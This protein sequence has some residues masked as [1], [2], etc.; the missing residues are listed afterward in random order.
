[1]QK[2]L[3]LAIVLFF[4]TLS[5]WTQVVTT[6]SSV[7]VCP[8]SATVEIPVTV[9]SFTAVGSISL[10]FAYVNSEITSPSVIYMDPGLTAWGTFVA[11][12]TIPGTII[13]SAFDPDVLP[14]TTGLTLVN[15]TTLFTLRFTIGTITTPAALTFVENSQG[16]SCEYGGVGPAYTPF[17]D[18]PTATYYIPGGV[19]VYPGFTAGAIAITNE[20]ICYNGDPV[21]I[22]SITPAS[23]GNGSIVY[24]WQSST[25]VDFASPTDIPGSNS[26]TYNPPANLTVSTWYRRQAKDGLC[27]TS[28]VTSSGVWKVTVYNNFTAGAISITGEFICNNGDP[29]LIG[30]VTLASGGNDVITYQWQSSTN[31]LFTSPVTINSN[32]ATYNPPANLTVSTW[33]RRQAKDGLCNT[34]W[35][36]SAGT[37][38]VTVY[39]TFIAGSI[40]TTD[41]T[42]CY[43]GDP[44]EI[45]S[46]TPASG[47]NEIITYQWQSSLNNGFS[48]PTDIPGSN[49]PTYNPPANLTT[50]TYYRRQAKDGLCYTSWSTSAGVW[51]VTVYPIFTA[52]AIATA[53]ETICYNG[54]P[55]VINS[56]TGATGGTGTI[57][58]QWQSSLNVDFTTPTDIPGATA[59]TYDPPANLAVS[60]WYRRQARDG[61]C[62]PAWVISAG[63]WSVT[64]YNNFTAGA[65]AT[66]G[67]TICYNGDPVEIGSITLAGGGN[68]TITYQWQSSTDQAF[69]TPSNIS[70]NT[71]TY[72]PPA[73]LTVTT[74]YRR[75]AK[76]GL[77][78]IS[79]NTSTGVW[80]VTVYNNFTAGSIATT[81]ETICYGGDPVE[82]GS[83]TPA[84]GGNGSFAYQ[85]QSSS[86]VGF[87]SPI[88]ITGSN[89]STYN[90]PANLTATTWYRR[91]AKDGLCNTSWNTSTG[92]WQVTV[93]QLQTISG[94]F[95]YHNLTA[96]IPL[97]AQDIT[98]QL[99][100][101]SD[102]SHST[103]LGT[104]VTD[105]SGNYVFAG[106]C[107]AC[108][109]DI[110][111]TTTHT[112]AGSVNTT[113]AAQVNYYGVNPY[114]IEK[115]RFHAGDVGLSG[116]PSDL[117]IN[118]TDA[119]RIQNNFVYGTA[120]DNNWTF[121]KKG[122]MITSASTTESYTSVTL[123]V[124]SNLDA[125][126][127]GLCTGDFNLS[128][129][130]TILKAASSTLDL[131]YTGNRQAGNNQE[132]DLPVR[133]V[134]SSDIGAVSLILKFPEDMVEVQDVLINGTGGQLDWAVKG[135]ELRIGWNSPSPLNLESFAEL[136]TLRMKT[137]TAF[138]VGNSIKISLAANPLNEL[139]DAGYE[140]IGDAVLGVD[141]IDAAVVGI[142][143]NNV[144]DGI[145]MINY[146][147]PF[148]NYTI[149]SYTIPFDGR[150]TLEISNIMGSRVRTLTNGLQSAGN[151][152]VKFNTSD[153][154]S[155]V[156][157][158][159]LKLTSGNDELIRT[160]KLIN[161]L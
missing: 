150:V 115:V 43:G 147:N 86:D 29:G 151:H 126:I 24:Q 135:N 100:K 138:T 2:N 161:N 142:D 134:N 78:N 106:L 92:T 61:V 93:N 141:I 153:L 99:Y 69:T 81:G 90:P 14:P 154:P 104:D 131:I 75:Q 26:A 17:I 46:I 16:N 113:D 109:Y 103:L 67:E 149:I 23:G 36:T 6:V 83:V 157:F 34:A 159:K 72:N 122:D 123:S 49:S 22:G 91:Q 19:T 5:A 158:A 95:S 94:T 79:C 105:G 59:A 108:D 44:A 68:E 97:T 89:S 73:N 114:L 4:T 128:F 102:V 119:G 55:V 98:V 70:S 32:T 9:N 51:K 12:T 148:S 74:W 53:G 64:V 57:S 39:N 80:K 139:A 101:S 27:N 112:T 88:T 120:F 143:E 140:V 107:P 15:G 71:P 40:A 133:L 110:V 47:G 63:V 65:I 146:P 11:N 7:S 62:T 152:N 60:T 50:S 76:D 3:L 18:T 155:G 54:N 160:I 42:I 35:N 145:T 132:F 77:C 48:S 33:Y 121:W 37:W 137:T 84:S 118:A 56:V 25:T 129:N 136:L 1:M 31:D 144:A 117:N 10:K 124:G 8:G 82:I 96:D 13:I 45:G 58:Y 156:Y 21:Q 127:Y 20:T 52:G 111:A 125:D 66:T 30:S 116:T 41:E 87:T 28:W 38:K 85:W 130:P